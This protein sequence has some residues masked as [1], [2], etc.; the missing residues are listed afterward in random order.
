[1]RKIVVTGGS[2]G[3]GSYVVEELLRAGYE[4][5]NLDINPPID[6]TTEFQTI[7]LVD[8]ESVEAAMRGFDA[9]VH[10]AANPH[11]DTDFASGA[12][13][14]RNNTLGTYNIFNAAAALGM[15]RV[16]WASSETVLGYPFLDVEPAYVPV[17]GLGELLP[18]NSY[19]VSKVL[20]EE[21]ARRYWD[22]HRL[23]SIGLRLSNV[24]Y[25][26]T[27]HPANYSAVPSYWDDPELRKFNLWG[28]V[29]ARDTA[30]SAR[31]A[32]EAQNSS[33]ESV[34]I[35]APDTIM[36]TPSRKLMAAVFPK[37]PIRD[38]LTEFGSLLSNQPAF[39]LMGYEP[40]YS[41]RD[42]VD[43]A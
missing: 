42:I 37:V 28:Y 31:L 39:E 34:I 7:D 9:V 43:A 25:T 19:A 16:V 2:G 4:V 35:A 36:N 33:A 27:D 40:E 10:F 1:M 24:H 30:K 22:I 26:G 14:F 20:C 15:Q 38:D 23:P 8:Y 13:R 11:P 6:R 41:W 12:D 17:D 32:L 21:L 18:R 5:L 29:D 3:S